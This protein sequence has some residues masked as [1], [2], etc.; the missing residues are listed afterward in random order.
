MGAGPARMPG[1]PSR[2]PLASLPDKFPVAMSRP[3][4]LPKRQF[5]DW[6]DIQVHGQAAHLSHLCR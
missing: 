5:A 6:H 2:C 3:H 4:R 1:G